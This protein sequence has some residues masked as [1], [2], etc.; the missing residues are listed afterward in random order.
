M[1]RACGTRKGA[2]ESRRGCGCRR[3]GCVHACKERAQQAQNEHAMCSFRVCARKGAWESRR[4]RGDCQRRRGARVHASSAMTA[5]GCMHEN[6]V[7]S[8]NV[9]V[10]CLSRMGGS[11]E[12]RHCGGEITHWAGQIQLSSSLQQGGRG[13]EG[14][15]ERGRVQEARW[16]GHMHSR[17]G[18]ACTKITKRARDVLISWFSC[19][20]C[21]LAQPETWAG[22]RARARRLVSCLQALLVLP[23]K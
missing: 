7:T 14:G 8:T 18:D 16:R 11:I 21:A 9:L 12:Y 22:G 19:M 3:C 15:D 4:V 17:N 20:R 13:L 10:S 2:R 6:H 5:C 23:V 1:K